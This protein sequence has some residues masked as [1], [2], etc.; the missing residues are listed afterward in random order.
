MN[1]AITL[2]DARI[3]G[4]KINGVQ[5]GGVY[6]PAKDA[7]SQAR[8]ESILMVNEYGPKQA[9]GTRPTYTQSYF[10]TAWNSKNAQPGRGLADM[11]ARHGSVGKSLFYAK[12]TRRQFDANVTVDGKAIIKA[13][14]TPAKQSRE[15]YVLQD[16]QFGPDSSKLIA[17]EIAAYNG[18]TNVWGVR[19]ACFDGTYRVDA[20]GNLPVIHG[21]MQPNI[22]KVNADVA[23]WEALSKL[24]N[25]L[26]YQ[27]GMT[28]FGYAHVEAATTTVNANQQQMMQ[29]GTN[30]N[31]GMSTTGTAGTIDTATMNNLMVASGGNPEV[32]A[33]LIEA[34]NTLGLS[35]VTGLI[36][37]SLGD[38][39]ML[40]TLINTALQQ[41]TAGT[42]TQKNDP[43][44]STSTT[45]Q[46]NQNAGNETV[47]AI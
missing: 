37:A 14:G 22:D 25:N 28:R 6:H 46:T 43:N 34:T 5:V 10:V 40:G 39:A 13:D 42:M 19:P 12:L 3:A 29:Q 41:G 18:Q 15:N 11:F 8:W 1:N 7:D 36:Q 33:K 30:Q 16:F 9:D 20:Q 21:T 38:P 24:R 44:T 47:F 4:R 45:T 2:I 27:A 23:A 35:K 32:L 17:A 26:V 31:T